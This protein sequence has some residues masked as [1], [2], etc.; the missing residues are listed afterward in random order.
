MTDR[1]RYYQRPDSSW[2]LEKR[3]DPDLRIRDKSGAFGNGVW[4][5]CD[6]YATLD[7][8]KNEIALRRKERLEAEETKRLMNATLVVVEI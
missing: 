7:E 5:V 4:I 3:C 8:V 2:I 1:Y 6:I